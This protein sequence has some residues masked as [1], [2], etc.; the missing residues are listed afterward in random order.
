MNV[1]TTAYRNGY[2]GSGWLSYMIVTVREMLRQGYTII[3]PDGKETQLE[4]KKPLQQ[5]KQT[6]LIAAIIWDDEKCYIT[7]QSEEALTKIV[8]RLAF[9]GVSYAEQKNKTTHL[10]IAREA[11]EKYISREFADLGKSEFALMESEDAETT[12][13]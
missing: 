5:R 12:K 7:P 10:R 1:N 13:H 3:E 9:F 2:V 6:S 8:A 11:W 4:W